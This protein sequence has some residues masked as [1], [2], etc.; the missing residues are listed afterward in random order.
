MLTKKEVRDRLR[1]DLEAPYF[2][3]KLEDK[4]YTEEEYIEL[5]DQ[6]KKYFD[7]YVRNVY[8]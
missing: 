7:D 1:K 2:N 6:I 3:G 8:H 5:R 4:E